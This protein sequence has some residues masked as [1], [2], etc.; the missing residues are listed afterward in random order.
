MDPYLLWRL[1]FLGL[2][3]YGVVFSPSPGE[4]NRS[5]STLVFYKCP[6]VHL[7]NVF[8]F[9]WIVAA[10]EGVHDA[11]VR[12]VSW[13][14]LVSLGA[15]NKVYLIFEAKVYYL[16]RDSACISTLKT[17][18]QLLFDHRCRWSGIKCSVLLMF[19]LE[20]Q[21]CEACLL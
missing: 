21:R 14:C 2:Y 18:L 10:R 20:I 8:A 19:I 11:S 16:L 1:H 6:L 15:S 7:Y 9:C 5:I 4:R 13:C 17:I 3:H 12:L